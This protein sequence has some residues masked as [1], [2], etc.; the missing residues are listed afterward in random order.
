[1][2][3]RKKKKKD[4][5]NYLGSLVVSILQSTELYILVGTY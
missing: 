4:V 5:D 2:K 3:E 1:M